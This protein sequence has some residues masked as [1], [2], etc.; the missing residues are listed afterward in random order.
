MAINDKGSDA[1]DRIR[2]LLADDNSQIRERARSL[3]ENEFEVI[4][5]VANG[6]EALVQVEKLHPDVLV[7]DISMPGMNGIEVAMRLANSD[8]KVVMLTVHDDPGLLQESL[9]AGALGYV[10]KT[11]LVVDLPKAIR[12]AKAER[13]FVSATSAS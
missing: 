11:S 2:V 12:E 10:I 8:T 9:A 4:G 13:T 1:L 5:A 3:L 6:Q 7:L